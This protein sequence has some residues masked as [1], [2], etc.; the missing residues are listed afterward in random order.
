MVPLSLILARVS[1]C[2]SV[3][4]TNENKIVHTNINLRLLIG[5]SRTGLD[6]DHTCLAPSFSFCA[7]N[8][9]TR[10]TLLCLVED[11]ETLDARPPDEQHAHLS[12]SRIFGTH[13]L[14][15]IIHR[16]SAK[17]HKQT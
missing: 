8:Y 6:D 12:V 10:S 11:D 13:P 14:N 7:T 2:A 9:V 3:V 16:M 5:A 4:T 1:A 17:G 15:R